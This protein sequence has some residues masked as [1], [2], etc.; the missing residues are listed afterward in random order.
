MS[1]QPT[2]IKAFDKYYE[3]LEAIV[4]TEY[5]RFIVPF[6]RRHRGKTIRRCRDK[7]WLLWT[8]RQTILVQKVTQPLKITMEIYTDH[9]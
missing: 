7:D 2:F 6:G 8:R 4:E 9:S 5:D 3:G 1:I